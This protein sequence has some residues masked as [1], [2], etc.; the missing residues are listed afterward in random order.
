MRE[1]T[2]GAI[3]AAVEKDDERDLPSCENVRNM[4]IKRIFFL[5]LWTANYL[6][7]LYAR[8]ELLKEGL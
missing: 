2:L 4:V 8:G 7:S 5:L 1:L 3:F 6:I